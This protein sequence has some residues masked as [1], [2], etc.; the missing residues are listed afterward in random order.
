M[1]TLR[2]ATHDTCNAA[3]LVAKKVRGIR[4]DIGKEMYGDDEWAVMQTNGSGWQDFLSANHSRNL[5]FD[6]FARRFRGYVVDLF[7]DSLSG[8]KARGGG[9]LR[10]EPDGESIIRSICKLTHV[11]AKQYEKNEQVILTFAFTQLL[12]WTLFYTQGD[13]IQFQD[14]LEEHFPHLVNTCIGRA[15][16]SKR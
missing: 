12:T 15:E 6:A 11:G 14:F 10:I 4:D 7:G 2:G 5:H 1:A 3:N 13:G 16:L 9:R 8:A